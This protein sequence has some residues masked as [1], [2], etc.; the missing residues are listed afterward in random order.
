MTTS[1]RIYVSKSTTNRAAEIN[2]PLRYR[3]YAVLAAPPLAAVLIVLGFLL[4]P[5]IGGTGR[6]LA[7]SYAAHPG[8]IQLSALSFHFAYAL[9]II[10]VLALALPIRSRGAWLANVAF[11]C[12]VVGLTTLPGLL[13]TDFYDVA[14]YGKLGPDAWQTVNHRLE[15]LPGTSVFL[16][17]TL[18]GATLAITT[19]LLA[20][21]R[22]HLLPW[23][24]ALLFL[25]A[26]IGARALPGGIGL[27]F[28]A[29]VVAG[30][31]FALLRV[32]QRLGSETTGTSTVLPG[33]PGLEASASS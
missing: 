31:T 28:L 20:S 22:A 18:V 10:P 11:V 17:S 9:F 27:L 6:S 26:E 15:A 24:P 19:A 4:D 21:S 29:L 16:V 25:L 14:I 32:D 2:A 12:A 5:D 23:W 1:E 7:R 8:Q 30:L 3:R 13:V 33:A